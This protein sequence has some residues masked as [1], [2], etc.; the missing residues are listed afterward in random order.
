MH[1]RSVTAEVDATETHAIKVDSMHEDEETQLTADL[2]VHEAKAASNIAKLAASNPD[3]KAAFTACL[4][5]AK[6]QLASVR[7]A[8]RDLEALAEE[9]NT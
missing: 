7:A 9:Q 5:A 2:E 1:A 4:S 6:E 8:T 3:E